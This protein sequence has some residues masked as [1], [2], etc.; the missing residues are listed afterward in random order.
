VARGAACHGS[1]SSSSSS[2][3]RGCGCHRVM[4]AA[5]NLRTLHL[6]VHPSQQRRERAVVTTLEGRAHNLQHPSVTKTS[7][8][9]KLVAAGL[10]VMQGVLVWV[11]EDGLQPCRAQL[12]QHQRGA[13]SLREQGR[14]SRRAYINEIACTSGLSLCSTGVLGAC[15]SHTA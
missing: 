13:H 12:Q 6:S 7:S 4:A 1:A 8:S 3:R 14:H 15:I 9:L 5:A 11:D 2:S 10:Q